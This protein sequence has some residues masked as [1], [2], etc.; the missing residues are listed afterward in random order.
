MKDTAIGI[1]FRNECK[2]V[3]V[4]KRRDLPAWVLPGGGID[5]GETAE[6]AAVREVQEE[7]GYRVS[8]KGLLGEYRARNWLA[9]DT[10]VY[11]CEIVGG[12]PSLSSETAEIGFHPVD[13]LPEY[14]F[15]LHR[16]FLKDA[17]KSNGEATKG[18]VELSWKLICGE[19]CKHPVL[20]SRYLIQRLK[21]WIKAKD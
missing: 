18:F 7:T 17:V 6:K 1:V 9:R 20:V 5:D 3:L 4:V 19:L 11:E 15:P 2:E 16:N 8:S 10:W 21:Q 13:Q 14:F 12:S